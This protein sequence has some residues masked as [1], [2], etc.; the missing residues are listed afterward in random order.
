MN[1]VEFEVL[2][3]LQPT[4]NDSDAASITAIA[5][6]WERKI[7]ELE[8]LSPLKLVHHKSLVFSLCDAFD[9]ASMFSPV[10]AAIYNDDPPPRPCINWEERVLVALSPGVLKRTSNLS[11]LLCKALMA[12]ELIS[13]ANE[14]AGR[15]RWS[16]L[17]AVKELAFR[18]RKEMLSVS[19]AEAIRRMLPEVLEAAKAQ[20]EPLTGQTPEAT[21]TKWFRD[22]G[23]K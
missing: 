23:V 1:F 2:L 9:G 19:R 7:D 8:S 17:D 16:R 11:S 13:G 18:R 21:V 20:G 5:D 14:R 6:A 22:A 4:G 15:S 12:Q 10:Y 3:G